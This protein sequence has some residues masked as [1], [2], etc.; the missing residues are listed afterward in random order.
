MSRAILIGFFA[1]SSMRKTRISVTY[2]K[3]DKYLL[4]D[5][6]RTQENP[7]KPP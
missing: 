3:V 1:Q 2:V 5:I 4:T 6:A 7:M